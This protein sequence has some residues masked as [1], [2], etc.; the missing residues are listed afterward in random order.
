MPREDQNSMEAHLTVKKLFVAGLREGIDEQVLQDYFSRFGNV[1]EVL[2]MKQAD[3]LLLFTITI[4][5][6]SIDEILGKPRGFAFVLFDDYDAVDKAILG[7]P[8]NINGRTLDIKKAIPKEKMVEMGYSG[9]PRNSYRQSGNG[10]ARN[11]YSSS[12]D[13]QYS[14]NWDGP[15][16]MMRMGN[17]NSNYNSQPMPPYP[18][19]QGYN[20]NSSNYNPPSASGPYP[21]SYSTS[22]AQNPAPPMMNYESYNVPPTNNNGNMPYS[23]AANPNSY[24][25]PPPPVSASYSSNPSTNYGAMSNQY[26]APPPPN[27]NGYKD[28][29][30]SSNSYGDP[31]DYGMMS[32]N[33]GGNNNFGNYNDMGLR[34][35]GPGPMRGVRG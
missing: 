15:Q 19:S 23:T 26:N 12:R 28:G 25:P 32:Q 20:S 17:S 16:D 35:G 11:H 34:G 31:N 2:V 13:D 33:Y 5:L 1:M 22:M 29:S 10:P 3:G 8:H 9:P 30:S 4:D 18:P 14:N 21:A 7:K 27:P 24:P 6:C